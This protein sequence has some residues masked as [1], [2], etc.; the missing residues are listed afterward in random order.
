MIIVLL[1]IAVIVAPAGIPT[2]ATDMPTEKAAVLV[3]VTVYGVAV[4]DT[5][6]ELVVVETVIAA[7]EKKLFVK[8][9]EA[10][11]VPGLALSVIV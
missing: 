11:A 7:V 3:K 9:I 4:D 8:V 10:D 6:D 5:C 1:G 2:A